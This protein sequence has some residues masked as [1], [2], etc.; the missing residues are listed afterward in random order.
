MSGVQHSISIFMFNLYDACWP[1]KIKCSW[2]TFYIMYVYIIPVVISYADKLTF[3]IYNIQ[4]PSDWGRIQCCVRNWNILTSDA[5][6][7]T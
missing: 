5:L 1:H 7:L 4:L 2:Q 6:Y 3:V